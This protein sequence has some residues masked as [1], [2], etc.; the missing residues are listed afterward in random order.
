MLECYQNCISKSR[1]SIS[2][3]GISSISSRRRRI[4]GSSGSISTYEQYWWDYYVS[5]HL[6]LKLV[7]AVAGRWLSKSVKLKN[8]S[9]TRAFKLH[10]Q[11]RALVLFSSLSKHMCL[12]PFVRHFD[13]L[14]WLQGRFCCQA[15]LLLCCSKQSS[16][17]AAQAWLH[18]H[19]AQTNQINEAGDHLAEDLQKTTPRRCWPSLDVLAFTHRVA[20]DFN[21]DHKPTPPTLCPAKQPTLNLQL[22][23]LLRLSLFGLYRFTLPCTVIPLRRIFN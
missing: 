22:A 13:F 11:N 5:W 7:V 6:F 17:W 19:Y 4:S 23:I 15:F 3:Y 10:S 20:D 16:R 8:H 14:P 1:S 9:Q 18:L 21:N 12:S 2:T